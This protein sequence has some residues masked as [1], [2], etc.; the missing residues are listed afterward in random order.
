MSRVHR[1]YL[2]SNCLHQTK[3]YDSWSVWLVDEATGTL[4]IFGDYGS[5]AHTWGRSGRSGKGKLDFRHELIRFSSDYLANKLSYGVPSKYDGE[6][7]LESVRR[8]ILTLRRSG[9]LSRE[10]AREDYDDASQVEDGEP[11]FSNFLDGGKGRWNRYLDECR[12]SQ[13]NDDW[14]L[15]LATVSF[16]R[17]KAAV[18]ADMFR[19]CSR[20]W[21]QRVSESEAA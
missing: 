15:H 8:Y 5:W 4:C 21:F 3:D 9:S 17:F 7:T 18:R 20:A 11:G 6:K 16:K 10:Q 1:Y 2:P 12:S 13:H 14:R 19:E